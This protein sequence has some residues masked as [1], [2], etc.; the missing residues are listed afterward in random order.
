MFTNKKKIEYEFVYRFI[1]N[2]KSSEVNIKA[3]GINEADALITAADTIKTKYTDAAEISYTGKF[4]L[5][6]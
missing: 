4:K 5:I 2:G 6:K 3:V 1:V